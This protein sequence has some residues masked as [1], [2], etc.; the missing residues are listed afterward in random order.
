[1]GYKINVYLCQW[2]LKNLDSAG[3]EQVSVTCIC[4]K[5]IVLGSLTAR[6]IIRHWD[7][8]VV[9]SVCYV[10][11]LLFIWKKRRITKVIHGNVLCRNVPHFPLS[12]YT[13]HSIIIPYIAL[14]SVHTNVPSDNQLTVTLVTT[15]LG[16]LTLKTL[17]WIQITNHTPSI[18]IPTIRSASI[19]G[20]CVISGVSCVNPTSMGIVTTQDVRILLT[21]GFEV[22]CDAG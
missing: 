7:N 11:M 19:Q 18:I 21:Q 6:S 5:C 10:F 16:L 14:N 22:R 17:C 12:V 3:C 9:P 1:M 15:V 8:V 4:E 13:S 2:T 20:L